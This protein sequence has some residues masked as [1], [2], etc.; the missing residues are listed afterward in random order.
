MIKEMPFKDVA[1][2]AA[3][4]MGGL[5]LG[6]EVAGQ[7]NTRFIFLEKVDDKLVYAGISN[8]AKMKKFYRKMW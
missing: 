4:A 2:V 3:P 7:L 6:Q 8:S 5:V 1:T